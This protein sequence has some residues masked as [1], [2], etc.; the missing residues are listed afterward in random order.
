MSIL[1]TMKKIAEQSQNAA[2]PAAFLFAQVTAVSPL[3]VR[4]DNRFD[5][6]A[7][8]L[9]VLKEKDGDPLAVGDKLALLRNH[10]GPVVPGFGKGVIFMA[11]IPG[12]S[13]GTL[14][15]TVDVASAA[16]QVTRTYKMDLEAGRC[17]GYVDGTEA[18]RQAILKI[19][20]TERFTYLIYSW[21]YGIE[22]NE[23]FGRSAQTLASEARRIVQ[24]AL[25]ADSRITKITDFS[26]SQPDKRTISIQFTAETIFG[27]IPLERTVARNV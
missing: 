18:M 2:V 3:V 6:P 12:Q 11:L 14:S 9:V 26:V 19:L 22:L 1:D 13:A 27:E 7:S 8:A 25:L 24:E 23:T 21:D 16:S 4:V 10:G 20:L 15:P 5:L 17:T